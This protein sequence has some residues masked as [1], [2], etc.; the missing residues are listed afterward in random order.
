MSL[1]IGNSF[2]EHAHVPVT[3]AT[4]DGTKT[5]YL[6]PKHVEQCQVMLQLSKYLSQDLS[7]TAFAGTNQYSFHIVV[8][9][10]QFG[11]IKWCWLE[12][13]ITNGSGTNFTLAPW[14][15]VIDHIDVEYIANG[16]QVIQT[17]QGLDLY[18]FL[19]LTTNYESLTVC[20]SEWNDTNTFSGGTALANGATKIYKVLLKLAWFC[21]NHV[22]FGMLKGNVQLH[23]FLNG[24]GIALT[25]GAVTSS[26]LDSAALM[27]QH[28]QATAEYTRTQMELYKNPMDFQFV[29][30]QT[31]Q[32]TGQSF[33]SGT[34]ATMT[35]TGINGPVNMLLFV[36]RS[37]S[38]SNSNYLT[39]TAVTDFQLLDSTGKNCIGGNAITS[40]E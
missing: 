29:D 9:P 36:V 37:N 22:W 38:L 3:V 32:L 1:T 15:Q 13:S 5:Y 31:M 12:F 6:S 23:I 10:Q 30:Y 33:T 25:A 2:D 40:T 7:T 19:G 20:A 21:Q 11:Y 24:S 18:N 35:L 17:I 4:P 34:Q 28:E 26:T 8:P 14:G 16:T 39:F 27:I